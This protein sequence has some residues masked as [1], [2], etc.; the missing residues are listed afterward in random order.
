MLKEVIHFLYNSVCEITPLTSL[1][2]SKHK[3]DPVDQIKPFMPHKLLANLTLNMC[4]TFSILIQC[5]EQGLDNIL[6]A[7]SNVFTVIVKGLDFGIRLIPVS[8]SKEALHVHMCKKFW[9]GMN[10]TLLQS[11]YFPK[12]IVYFPNLIAYTYQE[13]FACLIHF[14]FFLENYSL[15]L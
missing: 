5:Y 11:C 10:D 8:V 6:F 9:L 2:F 15:I 7:R 1:E 3:C 14:L 12:S 13:N 4:F